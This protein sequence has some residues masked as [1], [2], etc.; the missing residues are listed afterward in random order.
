MDMTL[1]GLA[2]EL[3]RW[4]GSTRDWLT[5]RV[6]VWEAA[7]LL[8]LALV[9]SL[10]LVKWRRERRRPTV[11]I[12]VIENGTGDD[13]KAKLIK[14]L[15]ASIT[16]ALSAFRIELPAIPA[17]SEYDALVSAV[18][19]SPAS[20][21]KWFAALAT[22]LKEM[23][24]PR[25]AYRVA[26][27]LLPSIGDGY[28]ILIAIEMP[29]SGRTVATLTAQG[30][31]MDEAA[32]AVAVAIS[33]Y[34]VGQRHGSSIVHASQRWSAP[35]AKSFM[36]YERGLLAASRGDH[37]DA[38]TS[39][40]AAT[41]LEPINASV[42]FEEA[43]EYEIAGRFVDALSVYLALAAFWPDLAVA[44]YRLA[45]TLSFYE[46]WEADWRK[47][48]LKP[49]ILELLKTLYTGTGPALETDSPQNNGWLEQSTP[50]RRRRI[51]SV[52]HL[53]VSLSCV[54]L[55]FQPDFRLFDGRLHGR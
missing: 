38:L 18:E 11:E 20:G 27:T 35:D 7:S 8:L 16:R 48:D 44:R 2:S 42:R 13:S 23:M 41:T 19:A 43:G 54:P 5:G 26:G 39:F 6:S 22:A 14:G 24:K 9:I 10:L 45:S 40:K 30:T 49:P 52:G 32:G 31:S 4:W 17:P 51:R 37:A 29:T 50:T 33:E 21:A 47:S 46:E 55:I 3:S 53:E 36:S 34:L 1:M 28:R 15:T 25:P 12:G